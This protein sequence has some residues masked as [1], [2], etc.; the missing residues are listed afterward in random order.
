APRSAYYAAQLWRRRAQNRYDAG[1]EVA[2]PTLQVFQRCPEPENR[3]EVACSGGVAL[4]YDLLSHSGLRAYD[5][6]LVAYGERVRRRCVEQRGALRRIDARI[7]LEDL[8]EHAGLGRFDR[9]RV[10]VA[11]QHC[12]YAAQAEVVRSRLAPGVVGFVA[13]GVENLYHLVQRMKARAD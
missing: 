5:K 13:I 4:A 9:F 2:I 7:D 10:A 11:I 8:A 12:H 6:L 1:A 3:R